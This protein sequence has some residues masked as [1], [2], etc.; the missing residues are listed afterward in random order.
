MVHYNHGMVTIGSLDKVV[1][2]MYQWYGV[3]N[4]LLLSLSFPKNQLFN[5]YGVDIYNH[6][7]GSDK[8]KKAN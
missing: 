4:I 2:S 7:K 5:K 6:Y 8:N 3:Q 1:Q